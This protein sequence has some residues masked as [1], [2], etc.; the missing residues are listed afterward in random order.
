MVVAI[1]DIPEDTTLFTIPRDAI[2]N[3]ETSELGKKIPNLFDTTFDENEEDAEPLNSWGSLILVMLYEYLQGE[4]SKWK[5]YFDV[6]PQT[7]DTPIFWSEAELKELQ[8]TCLT[9]EKIGKQESDDMLKTRILPIV[10]KNASVFYPEG[11][12]QQSEDELLAVAHRIGST[13]M[14]YAFDLDK[15]RSVDT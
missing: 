12:A 2:I 10:A 14:A 11:V 3:T 5:P 4:A 1:K 13:I 7:F 6:L 8:G 9:S 15:N